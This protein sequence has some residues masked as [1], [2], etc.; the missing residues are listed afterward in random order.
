MV[1]MRTTLLLVTSLVEVLRP[2]PLP[3]IFAHRN[4]ANTL[5]FPETTAISTI[6]ANVL[7]KEPKCRVL[8][9]VLAEC[10]TRTPGFAT[11]HSTKQA[12]CLCYDEFNTWVP[13]LFDDAAKTC[14]DHASKVAP[15]GVYNPLHQIESFCVEVGNVQV[16]T[17]A[18][19][20]GTSTGRGL[21]WCNS[22]YKYAKICSEKT[23]GFMDLHKTVQAT[24]LCYTTVSATAFW[25]PHQF[26]DAAGSCA[27]AAF[28]A[29]KTEIYEAITSLNT[30]CT[31]IGDRLSSLSIL[32]VSLVAAST[33]STSPSLPTSAF[34]TLISST[35]MALNSSRVKGEVT[36]T[37]T[38]PTKSSIIPPPSSSAISTTQG[39]STSALTIYPVPGIP[40]PK[41]EVPPNP[42]MSQSEGMALDTKKVIVIGAVCAFLVLFL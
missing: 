34:V 8:S 17:T 10:G 35:D 33:T 12:Q 30:F 28:N 23:P 14:A 42:G 4:R 3:H 6:D 2:T 9:S 16:P 15:N 21:S 32:S 36:S 37:V 13:S 20:T 39:S 38:L 31:S 11:M 27:L 41:T 1:T 24:C 7:L 22:V 26:D 40:L 19:P 18:V 25:L 5:P 29:Q